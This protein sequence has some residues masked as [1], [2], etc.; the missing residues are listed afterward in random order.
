LLSVIDAVAWP[1]GWLVAV[2][3]VP[4]PGVLGQVF[5]ALLILLIL[6]RSHRALVRNERY[7]FTT[8]RW[9]GR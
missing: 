3:A 2:S 8:W 7:R 1:A 6:K 5:G 4:E 9:G